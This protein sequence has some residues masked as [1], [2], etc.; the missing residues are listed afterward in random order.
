MDSLTTCLHWWDIATCSNMHAPVATEKWS[1]RRLVYLFHVSPMLH[2]KVVSFLPPG[3]KRA[4][5]CRLQQIVV[6]G[7]ILK[8]GEWLWSVQVKVRSDKMVFCLQCWIVVAPGACISKNCLE[9]QQSEW[10]VLFPSIFPNQIYATWPKV[11]STNLLGVFF[12]SI[13]RQMSH[14]LRH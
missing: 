9:N 2:Q 14:H 13:R 7:A 1:G 3:L 10:M 11:N 5:L 12:I 4:F 6:Q 8:R